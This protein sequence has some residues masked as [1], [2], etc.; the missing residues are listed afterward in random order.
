MR[1]LRYDAMYTAECVKK[2]TDKIKLH[3][4]AGNDGPEGQKI[5][6]YTISLTSPLNGMSGQHHALAVLSPGNVR[7]TL[8]RRLR[9]R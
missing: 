2:S 9:I 3:P 8:Y 7:Y 6:S 1:L 5:Y 4:R